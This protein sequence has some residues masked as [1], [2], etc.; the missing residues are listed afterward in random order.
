MR[1]RREVIHLVAVLCVCHTVSCDDVAQPEL[2]LSNLV[3]E[4]PYTVPFADYITDAELPA[5]Q[6]L[7]LASVSTRLCGTG[8]V[9]TSGEV[10][11]TL[12]QDITELA[13]LNVSTYYY[14]DVVKAVQSK[15]AAI[16]HV[17]ESGR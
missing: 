2:E 3:S 5:E 16:Y 10:N 8:F 14:I 13:V 15:A 9:N 12:L 6:S 17:H 4:S 11:R 7:Q 1:W